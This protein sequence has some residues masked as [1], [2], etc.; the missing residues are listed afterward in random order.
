[1]SVLLSP[2]V[3]GVCLPQCK[4]ARPLHSA[5]EPALEGKGV[6]VAT[7]RKIPGAQGWSQE[8][9]AKHCTSAIFPH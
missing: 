5:E 4:P 3:Y 7:H 6:K 1:M 8:A 2:A 9:G